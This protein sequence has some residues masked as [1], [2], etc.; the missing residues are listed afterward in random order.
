MEFLN[1]NNN[2]NRDVLNKNL[3]S[4]SVPTGGKLMNPYGKYLSVLFLIFFL[5][6][7]LAAQEK[8]TLR[9]LVTDSTSGEA[10]PYGNALIKE[11]AL[12]AS[13]DANGFFLIPQIP[14][15]HQ[16]TLLL[17][18]VGY[19]TKKISFVVQPNKVTHIDIKLSPSG[20][21][22]E[23]IEKVGHRIIEENATDIGL[24]RLS[25]KD[26]ERLPQGVE[27]DVFRSLQAQPGVQTTGDV[28]SR[29]YVR[30]GASNQN[31]VLF[32]GVTI[33]NPFHAMGL[34][35]AVDP[36]MINSAEFYKGGFTAEYGSRLSSVLDLVTK[37]GNKNQYSA[38]ASMSLLTGKL[39]VEGP[40]PDGSIIVT[41]RKSTSTEVL[42]KFLNKTAPFD[43]YDISYK[44]NY[45]LPYKDA[46]SKF[47]V[48]GFLSYDEVKNESLIKEDFNWQNNLF[49]FNWFLAGAESPLFLDIGFSY[50]SFNGELLPK[51]S[52]SKQKSN[53]LSDMTFK[54]DFVYVYESRDELN[55][56]LT[57]SDIKTVLFQENHLGG[58]YDV[59]LNGSN[60]VAFVKYKMLRFDNI[61][62]DVG[63]RYNMAGYTKSGGGTVE[64]RVSMTLRILPEIAIKG[65]WGIYQQELVTLTD[66]DDIITLY[67][68]WVITPAY[69]KP[70]KATHYGAGLEVDFMDGFSFEGEVYYKKISDLAILNKN[71]VFSSDRDF[72]AGTGDSYGFESMV[73]I[74]N[75]LLNLTA[76]YTLSW[77]Y[78]DIDGWLYHPRY[79]SRHSVNLSLELNV[80][81]G[82]MFSSMW[83]YSKGR[84]FTQTV[85]YYD[86][87][88]P[89]NFDD[90]GNIFQDYFV[91]TMLGDRNLGRL[92]DYHRLDVNLSK[93]FDFNFVKIH[94]TAS[95]I[96]VY[97]R[98]NIFYF[99]RETGETVNALPFLPTATIKVEL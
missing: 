61:G 67:E 16:Y 37:D 62:L 87:F 63:V 68:P 49:G 95:I 27:L 75:D 7:I 54:M 50:S 60:I 74:N 59:S 88:N 32:N 73:N 40:I 92:P 5:T 52:G 58:I 35:S 3:E 71:K 43:F 24:Q 34:F 8:G 70:S 29:Y 9:G 76:S 25:I 83:F 86:K 46:V 80:G 91:Y 44:L 96:N 33:Y 38:T 77:A 55:L 42:K 56:G 98:A 31:L 69:I 14:A 53:E 15:N 64:P 99:E 2:V 28:S 6:A 89:G 93:R 36:E 12:G 97:D 30:G 78:N 51:L 13:T 65:A 57:F 41:G 23:T 82:W 66:D 47:T 22:L 4:N 19:S 79:D 17:S 18:Y 39:L 21:Q 10:L 11:L 1:T 20:V 72:I 94:L 85:G 48:F 84:P 26:L 45:T 81:K 90:P